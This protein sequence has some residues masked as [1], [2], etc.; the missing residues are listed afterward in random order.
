MQLKLLSLLKE[1]EYHESLLLYK[2]ELSNTLD[3][4]FITEVNVFLESN[5]K[6]KELYSKKEEE[7][8]NYQLS[9]IEDIYRD[10]KDDIIEDDDSIIEPKGTDIKSIYRTIVK[11]TH[12]DIV[13]NDL[14]NNYY[15]ESTRY[16]DNL[17]I[18][19]LLILC[20]KLNIEFNYEL[21]D[22]DA[23]YK[24]IETSK[25]K[26]KFLESTY[27]W[28]WKDTDKKEEVILDYV[29]KKINN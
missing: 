3:N 10:R 14:L 7:W 29:T 21:L 28:K 13:K 15:I 11:Q 9:K 1:L 6:L 5:K 23:L 16:Y 27:S 18:N 22:T 4:E 2:E 25:S 19:S 8:N 20:L 26:I 12:P 17:D 24:G